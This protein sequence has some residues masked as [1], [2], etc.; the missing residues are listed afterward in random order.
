MAEL[1][2]SN[3]FMGKTYFSVTFFNENML[4]LHLLLQYTTE[5]RINTEPDAFD[6][7]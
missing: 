4:F 1:L 3:L 7:A 6:T 2:F 5:C